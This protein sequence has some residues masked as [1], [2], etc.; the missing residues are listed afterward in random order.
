MVGG[1]KK[2]VTSKRN[3]VVVHVNSQKLLQYKQ[4]LHVLQSDKNPSMAP[5]SGYVVSPLVKEVLS[6][7]SCWDK[8]QFA[9]KHV[10]SERL[11][12]LLQWKTTHLRTERQH[13][14]DFM[15][16]KHRH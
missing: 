8:G 9:F 16:L 4:D 2:T 3:R 7:D 6:I 11:A 10:T 15:G 12:M 1:Y 13:K 14:F 5:G